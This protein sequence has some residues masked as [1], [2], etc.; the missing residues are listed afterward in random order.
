MFKLF[1]LFIINLKTYW[2]LARPASV[3][4]SMQTICEAASSCGDS[5]GWPVVG[6][7]GS[8]CRNELQNCICIDSNTT[9]KANHFS[10]QFTLSY[11]VGSNAWL[12]G[13]LDGR[14]AVFSWGEACLDLQISPCYCLHTFLVPLV[15][16]Q[17]D[18]N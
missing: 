10:T 14:L 9:S 4:S 17:F 2:E 12:A 11:I 8:K 6:L 7:V 5:V 13:G 18:C 1:F 3:Q 15:F 16:D